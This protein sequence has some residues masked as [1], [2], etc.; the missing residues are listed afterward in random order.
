MPRGPGTPDTLNGKAAGRYS[1]VDPKKEKNVLDPNQENFKPGS[2]MVIMVL[3]SH[4]KAVKQTGNTQIIPKTTMTIR[5][6]SFPPPFK[7]SI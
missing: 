1:G 4:Y 7:K 5:G 6:F 3:V 2:G